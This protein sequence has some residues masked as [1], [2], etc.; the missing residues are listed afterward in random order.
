MG[1]DRGERTGVRILIFTGYGRVRIQVLYIDGMLRWT[2]RRI[3]I[4]TTFILYEACTTCEDNERK[5]V[6]KR[7]F[8]SEKGESAS[9][10]WEGGL[11]MQIWYWTRRVIYL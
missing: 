1:K 5:L 9:Y 8:G 2:S 6:Y 7:L 10:G 4:Y 11:S 3:R